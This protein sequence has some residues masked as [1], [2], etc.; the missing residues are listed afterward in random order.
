MKSLLKRLLRV[1]SRS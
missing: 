1:W